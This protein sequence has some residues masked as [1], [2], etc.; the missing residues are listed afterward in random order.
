MMVIMS[1]SFLGGNGGDQ[2]DQED[3]DLTISN[4]TFN[5]GKF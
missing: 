3:G 1:I 5:Y 2:H 4:H